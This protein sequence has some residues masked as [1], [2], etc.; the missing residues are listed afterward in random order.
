MTK[1][2][3]FAGDSNAVGFGM[4]LS[5]VPA[6]LTLPNANAF[7][8]NAGG[9]YWGQLT[10]G[11]NTGTASNPQAW[12]PEAQFAYAFGQ[13]YPGETLLII[14][15]AK[16]STPL[17]LDSV[18]VDW[19][20]DSVGEMF[21]LATSTIAD[22][23]TAFANA[24]GYPAP[25]IDAVMWVGGPNDSF[26]ATRAADYDDN[27]TDLFAAIRAEWMGQTDGEIVYS[28]MT[29]DTAVMPFNLDVRVAQWAV[30]QADPDAASFKTIG[31]GLAPDHIHYDA[32]GYVQL[33]QGLFD[34][35]LTL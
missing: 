25:P 31:Y 1:V 2:F 16:G 4:N 24:Q 12:G 14:K 34:T 26:S 11:V 22:A 20:P 19:S 13:A 32:T 33:G 21:D 5:T 17:A 30:D 15:I 8:F 29:D 23:R 28:R 7:I 18:A 27:L 9:S 3:V 6:G 35:W 10:P